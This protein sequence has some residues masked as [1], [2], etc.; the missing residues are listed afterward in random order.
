MD[1]QE[2]K[3]VD[4][5]AKG[6]ESSSSSDDEMRVRTV[7]TERSYLPEDRLQI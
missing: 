5:T 3:I 7:T 2:Q 1:F 6:G 4:D